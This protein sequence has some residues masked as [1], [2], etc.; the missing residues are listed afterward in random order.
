LLL[1]LVAQ[2]AQ[3]AYL[4]QHSHAARL[5]SEIEEALFDLPAPDDEVVINWAHVGTVTEL[6]KQLKEALD[7]LK[8]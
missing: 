2:S 6:C 1:P 7:F 8:N 3:E 5:L 4:D